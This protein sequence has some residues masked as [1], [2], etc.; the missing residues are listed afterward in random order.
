MREA[1]VHELR[2]HA[3]DGGVG[4]IAEGVPTVGVHAS[5]SE[6]VV[7]ENLVDD[8]GGLDLLGDDA[9]DALVISEIE[10]DATVAGVVQLADAVALV[11]RIGPVDC[12]E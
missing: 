4:G 11:L 8:S 3:D 2:E 10:A 12:G 5:V 1:V 7:G 6:A 9:L